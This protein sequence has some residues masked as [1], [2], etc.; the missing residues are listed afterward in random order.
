MYRNWLWIKL[1]LCGNRISS[2]KFGLLKHVFIAMDTEGIN[3]KRL[4]FSRKLKWQGIGSLEFV[5]H[6]SEGISALEEKWELSKPS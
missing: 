1:S 3:I 4:L 5:C 6:D 2:I